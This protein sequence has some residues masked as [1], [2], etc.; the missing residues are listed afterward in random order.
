VAVATAAFALAFASTAGAHSG[1][2]NA[3]PDNEGAHP[4]DTDACST[5]GININSVAGIYN[6][7]HV[8]IHHDGCYKGFPSSGKPTY[9]VSR[10]QCDAWFLYDMQASC[11]WPARGPG[12]DV[13]GRR[14]MQWATNY[15]YA[16][17]THA[18]G[19]YKG[20]TND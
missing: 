14:C 11:R 18:S 2:G 13:G 19:A 7:R 1:Q 10:S 8:C 6:F 20:P 9:W 3:L 4:W 5:P 12:R 16:V 15:H 17:R